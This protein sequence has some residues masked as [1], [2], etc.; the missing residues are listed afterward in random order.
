VDV[1]W[2]ASASGAGHT[3]YSYKW[4]IGTALQ[5]NGTSFTK[6]YCSPTSVTV[7]AIATASDNHSDEVTFTTTITLPKPTASISGPGEVDLYGSTC[8]TITWYAS[9]S[10]GTSPYT[11]SWTIGTSTTVLSTTNSLSKTVCSTQSIDVKLAV[12]DSA[13][14]TANATFNTQVYKDTTCLIGCP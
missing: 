14:Q 1:T 8:Q 9:V 10:G 6:K 4:Y 3:S 2:T 5:K 11:Y 7:K 13:S 12:R